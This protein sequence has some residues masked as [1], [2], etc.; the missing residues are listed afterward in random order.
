M[1]KTPEILEIGR[2][3]IRIEIEALQAVLAAIN[4][5][6]AATVE[7]IF[8]GSG[9]LIVT[10]I[11]KS[12]IIG[13]KIVA[14]MNSTGSPAIFM[15]AADAIHGDLGMVQ[16]DD[17]V[18]CIS[19]SGDT[20]EI[21][22]LVPL[23]KSMGNA[24]IA[25]TGNVNS[26]LGQ[27]ADYLLYTPIKEEADPNNLAP[28]ASTTAQ[29]ALGDA[30]AMALLAKKGFTESDFARFHPGGTLG[31]QLYLRVIDLAMHH[32]KP[33]VAEDASL[34][35]IIVEMT[36]K[37]LGITA[38]LNE[39]NELV[40]V[41]TDGDLRRML[42]HQNELGNIQA[43]QIMTKNPKT[44]EAQDLA[45]EA[46]L[47]MKQMNLNQLVVMTGKEYVGIIHLQDLIKEGLV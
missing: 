2:N 47:L 37:R 1:K 28:T 36:S 12:A 15:H 10:G 3:T 27:A 6:F 38:V 30:V 35:S 33:E 13:Q 43:S 14:T 39:A 25:M 11:G 5:D 17:L 20:P 4:D 18:L 40:G 32:Q 34:K 29:L 42:E 31:K 21:K 44:I 46:L 41:I 22:V 24:L 23:V 19:K 16:P 8:V 7:A 26:S 9:R 45:V